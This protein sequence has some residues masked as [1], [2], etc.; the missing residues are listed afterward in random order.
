MNVLQMTFTLRIENGNGFEESH[1][2]NYQSC[3][4]QATNELDKKAWTRVEIMKDGHVLF[5][6]NKMP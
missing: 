6:Q 4:L 1:P 3:L 2:P 5:A